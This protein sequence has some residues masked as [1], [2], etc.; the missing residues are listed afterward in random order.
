MRELTKEDLPALTGIVEN[1][2]AFFDL[3]VPAPSYRQAGFRQESRIRDF[4]HS[5][6]DRLTYVKRFTT[7]ED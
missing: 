1:H 4:D 5:G 2:G 7:V 3:K 6:D